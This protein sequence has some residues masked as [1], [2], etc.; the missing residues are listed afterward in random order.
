MLVVPRAEAE[1][2]AV[3]VVVV[4]CLVLVLRRVEAAGVVDAMVPLSRCADGED[5][6]IKGP[7]SRGA[8][9]AFLGGAVVDAAGARSMSETLSIALLRRLGGM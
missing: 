5:V 8:G 7:G 2:E 4:G 3:S 1:G 9:F 6:L